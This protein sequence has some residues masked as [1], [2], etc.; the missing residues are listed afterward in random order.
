MEYWDSIH[1]ISK[2]HISTCEILP[3]S[4]GMFGDIY[5]YIHIYEKLM[6]TSIIGIVHAGAPLF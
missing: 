2:G 5:I 6:K 3:A 4:I 1:R